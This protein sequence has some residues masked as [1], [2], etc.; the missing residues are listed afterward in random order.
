MPTSR[1]TISVIISTYNRANLL[2]EAINSLL[3]QSRIPDEIIVVDDGSTDDTSE[4][5]TKYSISIRAIVQENRGHPSALNTGIR[6]ASG[7]LIAFLD[8]DDVL[9]EDSI[10]L[11]A[12][13]LETHPDTLAVY[14]TAYMTDLQ[15]N[16][17]GWFRPPP[18]PNGKIFHHL[19]CRP[20][21]PIHA[22]MLRRKA[23][24]AVGYFDETLRVQHDLD[25][26][27]RFGAIYPF[28]SIDEIIAYYRVH[29]E[30]SVIKQA[31]ELNRK[32]I[33]VQERLIKLPAFDNLTPVQQARAYTSIGKKYL[34]LGNNRQA[35]FWLKK[36]IQNDRA[37]RNAYSMFA[38]S[39][40]GNR[41]V[42]SLVNARRKV[43]GVIRKN[44]S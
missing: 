1:S 44:R 10:A 6:A 16:V 41:M 34:A 21:F 24:E 36:A 33:I 31:D 5:L 26:W 7:D 25:Y 14:G 43:R 17:R 3:K 11:R 15:N 9:P 42:S 20:V 23:I 29:D 22:V 4:I 30:M 8:S 18:L 37:N 27:A 38:M 35:Q 40:L 32:G 39:L 2:S 28:A 19:V 12:T 13:Y